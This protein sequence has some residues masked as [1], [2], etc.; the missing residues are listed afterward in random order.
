MNQ[1]PASAPRHLPPAVALL[2]VLLLVLGVA[3]LVALLHTVGIAGV[4]L[5]SG[6][7]SSFA[8]VVL[9]ILRRRP[10]NAD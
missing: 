10:V 4:V 5:I 8:V 7:L 2:A 9:T 1:R 3:V 6:V